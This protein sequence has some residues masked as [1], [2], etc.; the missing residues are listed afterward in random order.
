MV[1]FG[2]V[3]GR[4]PRPDLLPKSKIFSTARLY[5]IDYRTTP[6]LL[7]PP[8][9]ATLRIQFISAGFKVKPKGR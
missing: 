3:L 8:K 6:L 2:H 4:K 7:H 5:L 9:V 1:C